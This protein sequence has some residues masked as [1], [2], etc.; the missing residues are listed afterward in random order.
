[1]TCPVSAPVYD[2]AAR[3]N[4]AWSTMPFFTEP[5]AQITL[6]SLDD[7]AGWIDDTQGEL[8]RIPFVGLLEHGA[9]FRDDEYFGDG[10]SLF[11][12]NRAGF[13]S[14]CQKLGFTGSQ[15]ETLETPSL[16]SQVLNDLLAQRD[17]RAKFAGD[18]CVVD[19]RTGTVIG[20]VS[21]SYVTYSNADF[22]DD[23]TGLLEGL[24]RDQRLE[25]H[26]AYGINTELTLR[27]TSTTFHGVIRGCGGQGEDKS[28]VGLEL[29]NTMVGNASVR[30]NY[31][32]H[33]LI[34]ANGLMVPAAEAVNR[35]F[36]S[37]QTDTFYR[38]LERSLDE[39]FRNIGKIQDLLSSLGTMDF[40]PEALART[41]SMTDS[42]FEVIQGLKQTIVEKEQL[43]LRY[44]RGA[45]DEDRERLRREHDTRMIALI[46]KYLGGELSKKVF[47]SRFRDSATLFDFI[48]VFT[49]YAKSQPLAEKLAI[50]EKSGALASYIANNSRKLYASEQAGTAH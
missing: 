3:T 30:I 36:H 47:E 2:G 20:L 22:L 8:R 14:V 1:M 13:G 21:S 46:P 39:V 4:H 16:V 15:L 37:G 17:I 5:I 18:E 6:D 50:E 28:K 31:F 7:V 45:S 23:I 41:R 24:P 29:R 32:L 44:P 42:V 27:F 11:H 25:F 9:T 38:R 34:C 35:V 12:F 33:R 48:N 19:E 26:G 43:F 40:D 49:E 10:D